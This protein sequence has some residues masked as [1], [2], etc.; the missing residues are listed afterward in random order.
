MHD[1]KTASFEKPLRLGDFK[2]TTSSTAARFTLA[3][4]FASGLLLAAT[5]WPLL[6]GPGAQRC[7]AHSPAHR[8]SVLELYTSEGCNSCPPVDQWIS[9][10]PDRG[11][12]SDRVIPLV[13]HV[14]YWDQLGW[15]DGMA[16]PQFSARQRAQASR[17]RSSLIYTPQLLL[18]GADY[19]RPFSDSRLSDRLSELDRVRAGAHLSLLQ[20]PVESG[21]AVELDVRVLRAQGSELQTYVAVTEDRLQSQIKGGENLGKVLHHDFVV[22]EFVGPLPMIENSRM[23]WKSAMALREEWKRADLSLVVFVQDERSGDILQALKRPL[24]R[25]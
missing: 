14:D 2:A 23:R 25:P 20:Q 3:V 12:K 8:I 21:V 16:K 24:C 9:T 15:Q 7:D 22:R 5:P 17:N 4:C 13:F 18:N 11:F 6:A 1:S 19:P 10:L